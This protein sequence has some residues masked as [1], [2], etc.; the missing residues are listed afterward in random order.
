MMTARWQQLRDHVH[1][2]FACPV[3]Q[4]RGVSR[5]DGLFPDLD[6]C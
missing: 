2:S 4:C 3:G 1:I 5:T 6:A